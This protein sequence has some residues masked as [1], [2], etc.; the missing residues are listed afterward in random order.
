MRKDTVPWPPP[1]PRPASSTPPITHL[2]QN[3]RGLQ[4]DLRWGLRDSARIPSEWHAIASADLVPGKRH[5]SLRVDEDVLQ[6]FKAMGV[7]H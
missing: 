6:F 1:L 5:I 4:E 7:G 2:S 3:L